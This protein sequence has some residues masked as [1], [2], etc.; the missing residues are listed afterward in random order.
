MRLIQSVA[1]LLF[2]ILAG[3][4]LLGPNPFLSSSATQ[5]E[6]KT[7]KTEKVARG[8]VFVDANENRKFDEGEKRLSG[9]K[10]SNGKV[11]TQTDADG[12]YVIS[13]DDDEIIFV[14]KPSGYRTPL[15]EEMLPQFYYVHKPNGSPKSFYPGVDPTGPLP[16]SIDFPLYPQK[17]PETFKAIMF[18]DPQPRNQKE[19]DYIAH[20]VIEELVGTDASFGVTLGDIM[21]D[22]LNL[23]ESSNRAIALMGI[24]WYNVVGNHDINFDAK[25]REHVNETFERVFGPS[26]YSF[27][28]GKV[29]FIVIDNIDWLIPEGRDRYTYRAAMGEEQLAFIERDLSM[30]PP[31]QFVCLM[32]HIPMTQMRDREKLYRMIEK[33]PLCISISG[34]TH[35]HEHVFLKDKDGWKGPKPHHHIVNVTVSGSWWSGK[36]DDRGIPHTMMADGAPNGYSILTFDKDGKYTLDFKAA[37]RDESYQME[38]Y[39]PDAVAVNK[40]SETDVFVNFFNGSEKSKLE[41]RFGNSGSW[42]EMKK[43]KENCPGFVELYKED[44]TLKHTQTRPLSKPK[45]STHLWKTSLPADLKPGTHL[46][47]VKATDRD[48]RVFEDQRILRV[49]E[50]K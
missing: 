39:T 9:I 34:H 30:I 7:A 19:V 29:H 21:F 41:I 5:Q 13:V 1:A 36:L 31:E 20:D 16:K 32:M 42:T 8:I 46:L 25:K 22:N 11:I 48:G 28:Y 24:P 6:E 17:E 23:Y 45:P 35:H 10:V 49:T 47:K 4:L 38:V 50:A 33:R 40:L 14:I 43:T 2:I 3:F 44:L 18:G 12:S 27:D 26:Y 37:G 15:S